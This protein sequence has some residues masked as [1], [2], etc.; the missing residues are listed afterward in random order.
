MPDRATL[1]GVIRYV[2]AARAVAD[3]ARELTARR[4]IRAVVA[5]AVQRHSCTVPQLAEELCRGPR[6][7]S[8]Q[9][10]EVLAEVADG[11]RS[12]VEG[13]FRALV[14]RAGLPTPFYNPR[15]F[16]GEYLLGKP[17]VWWPDAG[18]AGRD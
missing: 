13:D 10:R 12:V 15:L 14:K 17:D 18:V 9:L 3:A 8:A 4:E 16:I 7:D 11:T 5:D 1:D 6:R 2:P